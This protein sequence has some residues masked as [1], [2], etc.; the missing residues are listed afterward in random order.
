MLNPAAD[1]AW[2]RQQPLQHVTDVALELDSTGELLDLPA[3]APFPPKPE[4]FPASLPRMFG[5]L[6][7]PTEILTTYM[8]LPETEVV[9]ASTGRRQR[10]KLMPVEVRQFPDNIR[11]V[12]ADWPNEQIEAD[13]R[14]YDVILA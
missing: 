2:S 1:L 14:G 5:F 3:S 9:S 4:Y 13:K 12:S 7:A 11:F 8:E 6:P 10:R